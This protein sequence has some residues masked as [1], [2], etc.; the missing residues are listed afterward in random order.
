MELGVVRVITA[1]AKTAVERL[2][3][4]R[5]GQ[6]WGYGKVGHVRAKCSTNPSKPL[7]ISSVE[8]KE[9]NFSRKDKAQD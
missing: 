2:E 3:Y 7:S 8:E 6:C 9:N 4:Q 1:L 5:Q